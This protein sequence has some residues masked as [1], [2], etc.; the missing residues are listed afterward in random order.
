MASVSD[1]DSI[2]SVDSYLDLD[3]QAECVGSERVAGSQ[4][5]STA[6][7]YT[8]AHI[9]FGDLNPYLTYGLP[10]DTRTASRQRCAPAKTII[11]EY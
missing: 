2:R 5:M 8:G 3:S 4:P 7:L 11:K 10:Q 1:P 6:V 9:N